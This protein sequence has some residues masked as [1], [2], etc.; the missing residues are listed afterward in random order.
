MQTS[1]ETMT[2]VTKDKHSDELKK[3]DSEKSKREREH[4]E[5]IKNS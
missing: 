2:R 3:L 4:L 1:H 5:A